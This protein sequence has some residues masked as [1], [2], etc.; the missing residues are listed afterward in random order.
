MPRG[1]EC[2]DNVSESLTNTFYQRGHSNYL[3]NSE[4]LLFVFAIGQTW[5]FVKREMVWR[6]CLRG[7]GD[8]RL[9]LMLIVLI[10]SVGNTLL[11]TLGMYGLPPPPP[12]VLCARDKAVPWLAGSSMLLDKALIILAYTRSHTHTC[13]YT[14]NSFAYRPSLSCADLIKSPRQNPITLSFLEI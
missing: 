7:G 1:A 5:V 2:S 12:C 11:V 13:I 9:Y 8:W 4:A 6:A 10:V 3:H 14:H